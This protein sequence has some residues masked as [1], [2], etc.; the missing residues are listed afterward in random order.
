MDEEHLAGGLTNQGGVVRSGDQV[1]RPA[2]PSSE[3]VHRFLA[4]L[5]DAGF[6]G[7]PRPF[8]FDQQGRERLQFV[9]GDVPLSP[10]PDWAQTDAALASVAHLLRRFHDA[11]QQFPSQGLT[12]NRT[13]ADPAGGTV[14]CHNDVELSNIVFRDGVAVALIDFEFAAPGRPLYDLAQFIRLCLPIEADLDM[15]RMGWNRG[16]RAA[17][18]RLLADSYGLD[19]TGRAEL[20]AAIDDAIDRIE[21]VAR[22]NAEQGG[23]RAAAAMAQTGGIDKYDRRRDWWT[24]HRSDIVASLA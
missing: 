20:P 4:A 21:A 6:D 1:L 14:V 8:E 22:R 10:Y 12:W 23:A 18:L 7:A 5:R 24:R 11:G 13:L 3:S 16:D 19:R 2:S 9:E 15:D 17:R